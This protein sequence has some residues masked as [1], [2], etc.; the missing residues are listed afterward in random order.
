MN[1]QLNT[2][3]ADHYKSN[4]QRARIMTEFWV[5][6]NAYCP[7]CG[8][9]L[10]KFEN[11]RPVADFLCKNCQE[12]FELKSKNSKA[13]GGKIVDGA[14]QT[15]IQRI[16]EN[17][18]PSFFLL[19]YNNLTYEVNNFLIIPNFYFVPDIIEKRKPLSEN[20]RRAGWIGCN[21]LLKNLPENSKIYFVKN[22]NIIDKNKVLENWSKNS[23]LKNKKGESK[24]WILDIMNCVDK[25]NKEIFSLDDVYKFEKILKEKHPKNNFI[26]DKIRQQL[27]L[28]RNK[29][30]IEFLGRGK[31]KKVKL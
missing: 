18:N 23:F 21:I 11:N 10:A 2:R 25:I 22:S 12:E 26:K 28:L 19:T 14:Y 9:R 13:V 29:G 17:N 3:I 27:Q 30:I 1:I 4:S 7:N 31:Y 5:K 16:N 20:A 8:N 15:M 6:E 24:G